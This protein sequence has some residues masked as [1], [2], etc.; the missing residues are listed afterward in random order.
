MIRSSRY[1]A[2]VLAAVSVAAVSLTA[3]ISM[4]SQSAVN[5]DRPA[6]RVERM[7][8]S[9]S[10]NRDDRR[11]LAGAVDLLV[12]GKVR[13]QTGTAQPSLTP[14]TQYEVEVLHS[15]KGSTRGSTVT[16]NQEGGYDAE[17]NSL[18]LMDGDSML[19]TGR[20]YVLAGRYSDQYGWYTT[21]AEV[22][23]VDVTDLRGPDVEQVKRR[24]HEAVR[25]QTP[26]APDGG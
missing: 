17:R 12:V 23:T 8:A 16:I 9:W 1:L 10:F 14:E 11:A 21:I 15:F 13:Q 7:D 25:E 2:V 19:E 3:G 18:L 5:N 22:G 26:F 20:V 4:S 24:Y 6:F